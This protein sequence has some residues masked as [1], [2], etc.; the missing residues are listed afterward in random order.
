MVVWSI[1]SAMHLFIKNGTSTLFKVAC[2]N[3]YVEDRAKQIPNCIS[4]INF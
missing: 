4:L 1:V 2:I 3:D